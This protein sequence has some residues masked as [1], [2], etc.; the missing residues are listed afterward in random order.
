MAA[1][2]KLDERSVIEM[3]EMWRRGD[4]VG[5]IAQHFDC[6]HAT[7]TRYCSDMPRQTAKPLTAQQIQRLLDTWRPVTF[8]I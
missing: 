5:I 7:V 1:G 4:R 6:C 3:R 2:I 8:E